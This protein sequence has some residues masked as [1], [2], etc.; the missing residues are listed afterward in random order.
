MMSLTEL[1]IRR[2]AFTIVLS[3]IITI[4]GLISYSHLSVHWIPNINPP[5]VSIETDYPGAS[6]SLIENEI[7]T[8]LEAGLSGVDGIQTISSHSK[9]GKSEI[10]ITF[11]LGLNINTAV[12]DVRS[13]LQLV[14]DALPKEAKQPIVA[15]MDPNSEPVLY[16]AFS[17]PNRS[18][19]EITDYV[20]QFIM[21][22]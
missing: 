11:K 9:Q 14:S 20:K 16:V 22:R 5:I 13:A 1:F 17:D 3:L 8:P 4:V 2:A 15:K 19:K 6:A 10:T 21:P 7:T 12:E 18:A